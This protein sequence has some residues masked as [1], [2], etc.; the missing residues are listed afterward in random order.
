MLVVLRHATRTVISVVRFSITTRNAVVL[1]L[2]IGGL[3]LVAMA[4]A[5]QT[6]AP[7]VLYPFA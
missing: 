1:A 3:I 7:F 4:T 5:A 2:V 6:A